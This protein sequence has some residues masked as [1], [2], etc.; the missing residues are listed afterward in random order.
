MLVFV[1]VFLPTIV[2]MGLDVLGLVYRETVAGFI[3]GLAG[4]FLGWLA[5]WGSVEPLPAE[6][7]KV[8]VKQQ[9]V[10]TANCGI[11]Q[12]AV[13]PEVRKDCEHGCGH[14]FHTGCHQARLAVYRGDSRF[15]AVC[16]VQVA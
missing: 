4:I 9:Q 11:C 1:V 16:N 2:T 7:K 3:T 12:G 5:W 8:E 14:V 13:T 15:C 6:Q 10:V